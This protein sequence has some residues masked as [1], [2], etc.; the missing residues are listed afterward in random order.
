MKQ[1]LIHL[2]FSIKLLRHEP[3]KIKIALNFLA[4]HVYLSTWLCKWTVGI[5]EPFLI[6]M[7]KILLINTHYLLNIFSLIHYFSISL[8]AEAEPSL[9]E[10]YEIQKVP[11]SNIFFAQCEATNRKYQIHQVMGCSQH[12][13]KLKNIV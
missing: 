10:K 11:K 12:A 3:W 4:I 5:Y 2:L 13:C 7:H 1:W 9:F 6:S 8:H